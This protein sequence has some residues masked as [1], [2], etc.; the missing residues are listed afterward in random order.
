MCLLDARFPAVYPRHDSWLMFSVT[1]ETI[2]G[3]ELPWWNCSREWRV[4]YNEVKQSFSAVA[5]H[6]IS[7]SQMAALKRLFTDKWPPFIEECLDAS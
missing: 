4:V 5:A 1:L 2:A 7:I 6:Y 3:E